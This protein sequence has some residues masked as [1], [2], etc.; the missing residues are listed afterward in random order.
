MKPTGFILNAKIVKL[1][2]G[3]DH[4][5][6]LEI[7]EKTKK[8]FKAIKVSYATNFGWIYSRGYITE[9]N[10]VKA[11]KGEKYEMLVSFS[12]HMLP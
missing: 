6:W 2:D 12:G 3:P 5:N 4:E 1:A 11:E 9:E 10:I 8:G 7:G